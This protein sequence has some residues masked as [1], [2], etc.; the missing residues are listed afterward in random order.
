[1]DKQ[2]KTTQAPSGSKGRSGNKLKS[3]YLI[4]RI[5]ALLLALGLLAAA[6]WLVTLGVRWVLD[7]ITEANARVTPVESSVS[8][9]SEESEPEPQDPWLSTESVHDPN[10]WNLMLV[11][12]DHRVDETYVPPLA[13]FEDGDFRVHPGICNALTALVDAADDEGVILVLASGYRDY[14]VQQQVF[15]A[16]VD[17][18]SA[19]GW[20]QWDAPVR[21]AWEVP[22]PGAGEHI[23][24]LAVDIVPRYEEYTFDAETFA[25]TKTGEW[26][27]AHCAEFGFILRYTPELKDATGMLPEPWHLRYVGIEAAES[28]TLQGISL[29]QYLNKPLSK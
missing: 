6:I 28:I 5:A 12:A 3:K 29:E 4:R 11:N 25:L 22:R 23:T 20:N 8:S 7:V 24:G 21:A 27:A 16:K 15:D 19:E 17:E 14:A 18:L 1:M 26:L 13:F 2:P 10:A 9:E